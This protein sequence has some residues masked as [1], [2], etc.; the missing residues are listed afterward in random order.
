MNGCEKMLH[1]CG[2][3]HEGKEKKRLL[4]TKVEIREM[5]MGIRYVMCIYVQR[6]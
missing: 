2:I 6:H 1:K 4:G 3:E 5:Y